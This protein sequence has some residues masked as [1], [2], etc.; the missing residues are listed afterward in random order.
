MLG[1]NPGFAT[2]SRSLCIHLPPNSLLQ[3]VP[4]S[5][6]CCED[7]FSSYKLNVLNVFLSGHIAELKKY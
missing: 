6:D 1:Q 2:T 5:Q 7:I 4:T 3:L